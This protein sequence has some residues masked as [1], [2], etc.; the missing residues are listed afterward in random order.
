MV[1]VACGADADRRVAALPEGQRTAFVHVQHFAARR[2]RIGDCADRAGG[3]NGLAAL[4]VDAG[5]GICCEILRCFADF[6]GGCAGDDIVAAVGIHDADG[7]SA[8]MDVVCARYGVFG[9]VD[10]N[11]SV[12]SFDGWENGVAAR[13]GIIALDNDGCGDD[14]CRDHKRHFQ[15][16]GVVAGAD[17]AE[18]VVPC[19]RRLVAA[20]LDGV[21]DIDAVK[22]YGADGLRLLGGVVGE[23]VAERDGGIR[24]VAPRDCEV[25]A[26]APDGVAGLADDTHAVVACLGGNTVQCTAVLCIVGDG[27]LLHIAGHDVGGLVGIRVIQPVGPA[28][29]HH[30]ERLIFL[31]LGD[32]RNLRDDVGVVCIR[33]S[34]VDHAVDFGRGSVKLCDGDHQRGGFAVLLDSGDGVVCR[35]GVVSGIAAVIGE[36]ENIKLVAHRQRV[37]CRNKSGI[38]HK[39]EEV[40]LIAARRIA[41]V[42]RNGFYDGFHSRIRLDADRNVD[43]CRSRVGGG[44]DLDMQRVAAELGR[45][46]CQRIARRV[47]PCIGERRV[48]IVAGDGQ[49]C[50]G[51][52]GNGRAVGKACRIVLVGCRDRGDGDVHGEAALCGVFK[53][54]VALYHIPDCVVARSRRSGHRLGIIAVFAVAVDKLAACKVGVRRDAACRKQGVRVSVI[55]KRCCRGRGVMRALCERRFADSD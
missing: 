47:A 26:A 4:A 23:C 19:I 15:R 7:G 13:I 16:A 45:R 35:G 29:H 49:V 6:K 32:E 25:R 11:I 54:V 50:L 10:F 33:Q 2:D 53:A 14:F 28:V 12:K 34:Y 37:A 46:F 8:R 36:E 39:R 42:G 24:D 27:R 5:D 38:F 43:D 48:V 40:D 44:G 9:R 30:G 52:R 3:G 22:V 20:R 17:Q 21:G 41:V 18:R 31:V 51:G 55:D 1:V